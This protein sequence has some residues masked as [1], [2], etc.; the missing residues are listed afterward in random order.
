MSDQPDN[1]AA[2]PGVDLEQIKTNVVQLDVLTTLDV[3]PEKV[4][5]R[6][7]KAGLTEVIIAG[8]DKD[9]ELYTASSV[10][11]GGAALWLVEM[12]KKKLLEIGNIDDVRSPFHAG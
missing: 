8:Y 9:G 7:L 5:N 3:P 4:L 10:A 12:F 11:D 2:L 6:A 1:L